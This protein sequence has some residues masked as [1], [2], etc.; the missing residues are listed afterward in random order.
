M[1][2]CANLICEKMRKRLFIMKL[3]SKLNVSDKLQKNHF[4]RECATVSPVVFIWTLLTES[5]DNINE[6]NDK[7]ASK[8]AKVDLKSVGAV[9]DTVFKTRCLR[10]TSGSRYDPFVTFDKLLSERLKAVKQWA[11]NLRK[12][13]FHAK[14]VQYYNKHKLFFIVLI[15]FYNFIL[16]FYFLYPGSLIG[17]KHF[18]F[19][20]HDTDKY[21]SNHIACGKVKVRKNI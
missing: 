7:T 4:Y 18:I 16:P 10:L 9:Y 5:K 20:V 8:M 14:C 15:F 3:I 13:C 12:N 6:Y 2:L 11:N 19:S 21:T 17:H 1:R